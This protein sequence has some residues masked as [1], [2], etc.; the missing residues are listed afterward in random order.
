MKRIKRDLSHDSKNLLAYQKDIENYEPLTKIQEQ[1]LGERILQGDPYARQELIIGY[2]SLVF[3]CANDYRNP[4]VPMDELVAAGNLGL[5]IA[6]SRFDPRK[7]RRFLFY[8]KHYIKDAIINAIHEYNST[9][10]IPC[11]VDDKYNFMSFSPADDEHDDK[12]NWV[13]PFVDTIAAAPEYWENEQ[14]IQDFLKEARDILGPHF[15][16]FDVNM[17][18][19]YAQKFYEGYTIKDLAFEYHLPVKKMKAM[20]NEL[21]LRAKSLNLRSALS[22]AA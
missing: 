11:G 3:K 8:A 15:S 16:K 4:K 17:L 5:T 6:A 10:H 7:S 21:R 18:L 14:L 19:E 2:L 22:K 12:E 13:R 9:M 1:E 20:I